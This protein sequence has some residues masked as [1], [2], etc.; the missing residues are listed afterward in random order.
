MIFSFSSEHTIARV[1]LQKNEQN[2]EQ[3]IAFNNKA[4]INSTLKYDIM[5]KQSYALVKAFKECRVYILHSHSIVFVPFAAIKDIL[6]Q[7]ESDG[8]R[9]K[10]IAT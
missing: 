2:L 10:W 4:L 7:L 5:E 6:T 3:P 9:A 8:R 1:I